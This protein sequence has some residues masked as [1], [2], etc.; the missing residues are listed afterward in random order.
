MKK[1]LLSILITSP[2]FSADYTVDQGDLLNIDVVNNISHNQSLNID[3]YTSPNTAGKLSN[4]LTFNGSDASDTT[5][6][7]DTSVI[8]TFN[9]TVNATDE[10]GV[11]GAR[12]VSVEVLTSR[13]PAS[14]DYYTS[15]TFMW[16]EN[17]MGSV[18]IAWGG[19]LVATF[20]GDHS[21]TS[22]STGGWTYYQSAFRENNGAD[23]QYAIYRIKN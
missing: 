5:C 14:G 10:L 1:L 20:V 6:D 4:C 11:A 13:E 3:S 9:F 18:N 23:A 12:V 19:S 17:G 7:Y 22:Y 15:G 16:S 2:I 8:G 21:M